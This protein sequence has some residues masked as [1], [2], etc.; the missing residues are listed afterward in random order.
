MISLINS[1]FLQRKPLFLQYSFL[2]SLYQVVPRRSS[3]SLRAATP[4]SSLLVLSQFLN[5]SGYNQYTSTNFYISITKMQSIREIIAQYYRLMDT[6]QQKP[7]FRHRNHISTFFNSDSRF[8]FP[9]I[10]FLWSNLIK[11]GLYVFF[12]LAQ[13]NKPNKLI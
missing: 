3:A 4:V 5:A 6:R 12:I 10:D 2:L 1:N 13:T 7:V 9:I 8:G 11:I